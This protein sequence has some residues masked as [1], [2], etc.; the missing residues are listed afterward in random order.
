MKFVYFLLCKNFYLFNIYSFVY[1]ITMAVKLSRA[2][3]IP[4][5]QEIKILLLGDGK[6]I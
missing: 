4:T 1:L 3:V 6:Y 2:S 5:D